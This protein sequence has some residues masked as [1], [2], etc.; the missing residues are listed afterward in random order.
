M[1]PMFVTAPF[2]IGM[3]WKQPTCPLTAKWIKK[4]EIYIYALRSLQMVTAAMKLKAAYS[5]EGEL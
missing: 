1:H 2:T 3:T 4:M 5:L